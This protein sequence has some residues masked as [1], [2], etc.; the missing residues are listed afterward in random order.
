MKYSA[1]LLVARKSPT[2]QFLLIHLGGPYWKDQD[3]GAWC[4]PKGLLE[5]GE[6]SL[7]A[8]KREW[9][10]ETG[11]TL[12]KGE[13][14]PLPVIV[15]SRKTVT[16][17]LVVED[18]NISGFTS[19]LFTLEWPKGSGT[20]Q[21][22]PEADTIEWCTYDVAMVRIHKYLRPVLHHAMKVLS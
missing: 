2:A 15:S 18:V 17:F 21:E 1:G 11:L 3:A 16:T 19:N 14:V 4:F 6:E 7:D 8:A 13:Y 9:S 10:E 12:P 20:H 5:E 22:F